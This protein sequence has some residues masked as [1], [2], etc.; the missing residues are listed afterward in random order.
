[1]TIDP[2]NMRPSDV[3]AASTEEL[4]RIWEEYSHAQWCP[5]RH[6]GECLCLRNLVTNELESRGEGV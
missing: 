1:M 3:K 5:S 2:A 6:S 4:Q